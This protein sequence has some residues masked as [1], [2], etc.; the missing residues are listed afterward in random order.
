MRKLSI[1]VVAI[2]VAASM[3]WAQ[4]KGKGKGKGKGGGGIPAPITITSPAYPDG[5]KIPAKYGCAAQG[6]SGGVSPAISWSGAPA[7]TAAYALIMHDPDVMFNGADV[8]HWAIF[9]I[10]GGTVSLP[11]NLDKKPELPDG[12][13]Q[14]NNIA[15]MPGYFN[16][17]PPPPTTHH[18]IIE[19]YAL[20]QKLDLPASTSRADLEKALGMHVIAKGV[21]VGTYKIP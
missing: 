16:P 5:G 20:N 9:D 4:E 10:P 8:L 13:K 14:L 18:Y 21:Y 7:N 1:A 11:E 3:A 19:M 17:C 15:G 2:S 12:S 6:Q